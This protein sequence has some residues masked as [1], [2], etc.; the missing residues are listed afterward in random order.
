MEVI[1][2]PCV[3]VVMDGSCKD[4]GKNLQ[5]S[6]P[7]LRERER[8]KE[9]INA[10]VSQHQILCLV[11]V[12]KMPQWLQGYRSVVA[13]SL[14]PWRDMFWSSSCLWSD[15][16]QNH[17]SVCLPACQGFKIRLHQLLMCLENN[18]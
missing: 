6:Q 8:Q 3:L 2:G 14:R 15:H 12:P 7:L 18:A 16:S 10:S 11:S 5:L 1:C 13:I 17:L 4:Y 9:K